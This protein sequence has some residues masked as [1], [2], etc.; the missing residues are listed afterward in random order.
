MIIDENADLTQ[1][2]ITQLLDGLYVIRT[3]QLD[4][5][6]WKLQQKAA[7]DMIIR[8]LESRSTKDLVAALVAESMEAVQ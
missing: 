2:T 6:D 4:S 3:G 5:P 1:F 7:K 8:E